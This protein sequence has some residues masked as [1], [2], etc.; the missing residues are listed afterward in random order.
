MKRSV[1][2][3][4]WGHKGCYSP[5]S[6][7]SDGGIGFEFVAVEWW[8]IVRFEGDRNAKFGEYLV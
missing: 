8:A 6:K 2:S 4:A 3:L 1:S 7:S 5:V